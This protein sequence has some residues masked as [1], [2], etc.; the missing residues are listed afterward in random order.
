M[1]YSRSPSVRNI[2]HTFLR[3]ETAYATYIPAC[4]HIQEEMLDE[5]LLRQGE[6]L[7]YSAKRLRWS[8]KRFADLESD[9]RVT[10]LRAH[11]G[12]PFERDIY[13]LRISLHLNGHSCS[14][15]FGSHRTN[16]TVYQM[17]CC[18]IVRGRWNQTERRAPWC[19]RG[20]PHPASFFVE[21]L[22]TW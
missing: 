14:A 21:S 15:R 8:Y 11:H 7:E 12:T 4:E 1:G 5:H 17:D 9:Q 6:R 3:L 20:R 10:S 16:L 19:L 22:L 2:L 18:G 13:L